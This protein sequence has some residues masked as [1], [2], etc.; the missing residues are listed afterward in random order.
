MEA[1]LTNTAM[2]KI[3]TGIYTF[4]ELR[5]ECFGYIGKTEIHLPLVG[6]AGEL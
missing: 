3:A 1:V 2:E 4:E 6:F 5:M